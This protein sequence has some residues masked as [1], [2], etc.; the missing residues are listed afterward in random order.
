PHQMK[1][2]TEDELVQKYDSYLP[3]DVRHFSDILDY[4]GISRQ[5][6]GDVEPCPEAAYR[7][8]DFCNRI[9]KHFP[10]KNPA[11]N[12]F[13]VLL[14][15]LSQLFSEA[16]E[17]ILHHQIEEPLGLLYLM[18]YLNDKFKERINGKVFKSRIDFDSYDEL[19]RIIMDFKPDLIGIR[20]LSFYKEFF[21]RT[22]LLMRQWGVEVPIVT[23]GP[24]ATSDYK[25]ILRDPHVDL[26]VLGE[27]ELTLEHLVEKMMEN[28]NK[29]PGEDV[30][31]E[32]PGI[33]FSRGKDRF[34]GAGRQV[35]RDILL[36][37]ELESRRLEKYPG[38]DLRPI[39]QCYDL[40]YVI[41]TSGSTGKPKGVMLEHRNIANLIRY[42][43]NHT[44]IDFD[45]VLQFTTISFDVSAQE[46]FS[47]LLAGG[48]L[49][50]IDKETLNDIPELFGVV[51]KESIKTLF[52]A[53]SFLKFVMN[54]EEYVNL[55][56]GCLRHIVLGGEQLIV[57]ERFRKY[58]RENRVYLHNHYGPSESHVV[59][60]L[61]LAPE[62]ELPELPSI[63]RPVSNTAIYILDRGMHL[64]PAGVA[65]ELVIGGMQLGRG[66]LN[67]PELTAEKFVFIFYRSYRFY[68]TY[69]SKTIYKTGDL[70][71]WLADRNL[72]FL[73]RLDHQV[74]VRGFRVELGEIESRL[75]NHDQIKDCVV[76]AG[77]EERGGRYLC[78]Y[79]VSSQEVEISELR[80][81]L[82]RD[83][84]DYMIPSYFVFLDRIPLTSNRKVDRRALPLPGLKAGDNYIG[85]GSLREEK[86]VEIW[87]EVLGIGRDMISI[88]SNFFELG[89]HSLTATI[90]AAK[91]NKEF[92]VKLPL[93]EIFQAPTIRGLSQ[94]LQGAVED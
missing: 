19:K 27:G 18:S 59:T 86:L 38:Q 37:D 28:G 82:G 66:Y 39:A 53:A 51:A 40:F 81:Y 68:R 33:A 6:L 49:V 3:F 89:G 48:G 84:P 56:P 32:I 10:V 61:S 25:L 83:L 45:R 47:T 85:P 1:V 20:T 30:L 31:K 79:M 23:G 11:G 22:V 64:V 8:P 13:R 63:G 77:A 41:Y 72:E 57:N 43:Y 74:K 75:L 88:E 94:Y 7:V 76:V 46:I 58:L 62:G 9:S 24:Y 54:E 70:A 16:H 71:R 92:H 90:L 60:A 34:K 42:Q 55:V 67:R 87:S 2:L 52:A 65:G 36:L 21:H 12:A 5:E 78:A 26:V 93:V 50:L 35:R 80:G 17:H 73:G 4:A 29:L 14:L 44:G 91:V 69:G 15:D